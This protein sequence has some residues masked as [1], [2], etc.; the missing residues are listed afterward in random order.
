M[1]S[2]RKSRKKLKNVIARKGKLLQIRSPY[3][4]M[5]P[6]PRDESKIRSRENE[7]KP[8]RKSPDESKKKL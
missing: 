1:P 8:L 6:N 5:K 7:E 2:E 3:S 4:E